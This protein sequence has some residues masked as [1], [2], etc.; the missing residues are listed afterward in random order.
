MSGNLLP[1]AIT[2]AVAVGVYY[3]LAEYTPLPEGFSMAGGVLAAIASSVL[4]RKLFRR[5]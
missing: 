4:T 2:V 1:M 3:L 5:G